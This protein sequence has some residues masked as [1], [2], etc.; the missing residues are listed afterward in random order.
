MEGL[1][2]R[3]E[4]TNEFGEQMILGLDNKKQAWFYHEDCTT[5]YEKVEDLFLNY[6]LKGKKNIIK[7]FK[8]VFSQMEKVVIIQFFTEHNI[9]EPKD[10]KT[11]N[12]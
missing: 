9:K 2:H 10:V 8:Y 1:I 4:L 3:V 5:E 12:V 6:K 11:L 7:G